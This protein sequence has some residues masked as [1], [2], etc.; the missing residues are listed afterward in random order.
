MLVASL[1]I[2]GFTVHLEQQSAPFFEE[3]STKKH[4]LLQVPPI[5]QGTGLSVLHSGDMGPHDSFR[6][7]SAF[8][9]FGIRYRYENVWVRQ[10]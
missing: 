2:Y 7:S 6:S 3:C 1:G 5:L 10:R 9:G 8:R 4:A